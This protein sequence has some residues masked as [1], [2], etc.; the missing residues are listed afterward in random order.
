MDILIPTLGRANRQT[1]LNNLPPKWQQKVQLVVQEKDY[2]EN[3]RQYRSYPAS[4]RVLPSHIT[5]IAETRQHLLYDEHHLHNKIL[6]LDDDMVFSARRADEP[7]KFQPMLDSEF[8]L[9]FWEVS[10]LLGSYVHAGIS[11]REGANRNTDQTV[12]CSRMMRALAYN[13]E[14]V[15]DAGVSFGRVPVMEDFDVTLQLLR[16]GRK[17][18]IANDWVHNQGG[19]DTSGG[20]STFRTKEVQTTAAHKLAELH[21]GFVKVV[22]KTTKGSWGGGTRTDVTI[23]WK[24]AYESSK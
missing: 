9:M 8:D 3:E 20:C 1:T 12:F 17:N 15:K 22:E 5:T 23:Y 19:S 7:T 13:R 2:L 18:A 14:W 6:M 21:P 11:H 24:K 10:M 4:I 16:K